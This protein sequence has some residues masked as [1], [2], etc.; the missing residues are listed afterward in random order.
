MLISPVNLLGDVFEGNRMKYK[1]LPPLYRKFLLLALSMLWLTACSGN[2][3]TA[4]PTPV[5]TQTVIVSNTGASL[6]PE[7]TCDEAVQIIEQNQVR[8][9][10]IY[11]EKANTNA[12]SI[13]FLEPRQQNNT[14]LSGGQQAIGP[15]LPRQCPMQILAAVQHFNKGLSKNKQVKVSY[16]TTVD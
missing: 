4:A 16:Y 1:Q 9:V 6:E 10:Q 11:K 5:L 12:V 2:A 14:S 8:E 7:I 13:I 3:P 15:L